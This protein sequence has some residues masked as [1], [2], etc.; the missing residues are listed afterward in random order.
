MDTNDEKLYHHVLVKLDLDLM[1]KLYNYASE[2][3]MKLSGI[4]RQSL[5]RYL[6]SEET[7]KKLTDKK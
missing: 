1:E 3:D 7:D 2:H 6:E 5:R 4:M